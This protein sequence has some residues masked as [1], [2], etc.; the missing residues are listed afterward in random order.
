MKC[1]LMHK[2]IPVVQLIIDDKIGTISKIRDIYN[3]LHLPLGVCIN[4]KIDRAELNEW[5]IER[6][7]PSSR[8]GLRDALEKIGVPNAVVLQAKCLGLSLTDQYWICPEDSGLTWDA[9]N[10]FTNPFSDDIGDI[11]L[12]A[13]RK[14]R[15]LNFNS[16]D[17]S[18]PGNLIKRWKIVDE[19]RC[20]FKGGS[21]PFK[22]QPYNE[23]IATK[24]NE[25]L[26][27]EHTSY[28]L[29]MDQGEP[30]SVCDNFVD[31]Y[32]DLI[33][34]Y[35]IK[36]T[37]K[38]SNNSSSYQ[39]FVKCA[40]DIG[41]TGV[42]EYLD[43][44]IVL[45]YI[46]ANEDR[47]FNNFG[48]IRYA[49]SLEW[50][51]FAPIYDNGSSLGY[52]KIASDIRTGKSVECKPFKKHHEEQIKLVKDFS[53]IDFDKLSDVETIIRE[54]LVPSDHFGDD[55]IEAIVCSVNRRIEHVKDMSLTIRP[56]I[57]LSA[58]DDVKEDVAKSY[59]DPDPDPTDDTDDIDT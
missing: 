56:L 16:P 15:V 42:T 35:R 11:L 43:K 48:V 46:I 3:V 52:D 19:V 10:F 6:A 17:G 36:L 5:W 37:Q 57:S 39:H 9:V 41:I 44:Q 13:D 32:T 27:I 2:Y 34:A 33:P 30:F 55:R 51:G 4:N 59:E 40:E 24:I 18:S 26:G 8:S 45:D 28:R 54:T 47:H 23:L 38:Q 53:W 12:G 25:L 31:Q 50:K 22:Q 21:K 20:L 49:E 58:Q 7:I 14:D 29:F 1:V